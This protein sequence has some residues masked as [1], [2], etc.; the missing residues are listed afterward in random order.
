MEHF[1]KQIKDNWIILSFIVAL[2]VSWTNINSRLVQ[3]E[4]DIQQLSQVVVQINEINIR[5]AVIQEKVIT[6]EKLVK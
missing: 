2:I 3:A 6:I 1:L 4:N 5:L